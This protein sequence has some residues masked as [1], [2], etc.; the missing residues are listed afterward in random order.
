[1]PR[2]LRSF[3]GLHGPLRQ[4]LGPPQAASSPF[5]RAMLPTDN[6]QFQR[7]RPCPTAHWSTALAGHALSAFPG[8]PSA[9]D[10][11]HAAGSRWIATS[12]DAVALGLRVGQKRYDGTRKNWQA[13]FARKPLLHTPRLHHQP[14]AQLDRRRPE[15]PSSSL[16][17]TTACDPAEL[18]DKT[19]KKQNKT[20]II[21]F[22]LLYCDILRQYCDHSSHYSC[23]LEVRLSL[24]TLFFCCRANS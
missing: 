11:R 14:P 16:P 7:G 21:I 6:A 22:R 17:W 8:L 24:A 2:P 23:F 20:N 15:G 19:S 9:L 12:R 5:R 18:R 3:A 10:L 13:C 4:P 1:M